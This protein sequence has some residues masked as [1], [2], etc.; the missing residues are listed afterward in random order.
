MT[1]K[2]D[3]VMAKLVL[4]RLR[5]EDL[6]VRQY[7][8]SN[9]AMILPLFPRGYTLYIIDRV[10]AY[11]VARGLICHL[12]FNECREHDETGECSHLLKDCLLN[13]DTF[14]EILEQVNKEYQEKYMKILG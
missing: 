7:D 14:M 2:G 5:P 9:V 3:H 10:L 1:T 4:K 6:I 11:T 13:N 8:S 12:A